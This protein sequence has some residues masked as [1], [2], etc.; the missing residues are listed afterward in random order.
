M[1]G[2]GALATGAIQLHQEPRAV[3]YRYGG[4]GD[5][6]AEQVSKGFLALVIEMGLFA[7]ED[8]LVLHQRLLDGLDGGDIQLTGQFDATDFGADPPG[9]RVNIKWLGDGLNG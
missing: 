7:E 9:Y 3:S 6:L 8:H 4:V 1:P 2:I 5:R